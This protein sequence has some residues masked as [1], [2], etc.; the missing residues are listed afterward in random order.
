[1]FTTQQAIALDG[2]TKRRA[3]KFR[4]SLYGKLLSTGADSN[5]ALL[6]SEA[7]ASREVLGTALTYNQGISNLT[8][9]GVDLTDIELLTSQVWQEMESPAES[10][11]VTPSSDL[12]TLSTAQRQKLKETIQEIERLQAKRKALVNSLP[13]LPLASSPQCKQPSE[14]LPQQDWEH[15]TQDQLLSWVQVAIELYRQNW[16]LGKTISAWQKLWDF[17]AHS[18]LQVD[19]E[20]I[21]LCASALSK[22]ELL[23]LAVA[24]LNRAT[25]V[26]PCQ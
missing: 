26:E 10:T 18:H 2:E 8:A 22:P 17:D 16:S 3:R 13:R 15:L 20:L 24:V 19:A 6:A 23:E 9:A 12:A 4:Q 1:M 21:D 5:A 25:E 7:I 11:E 14:I